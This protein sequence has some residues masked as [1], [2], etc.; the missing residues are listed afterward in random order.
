MERDQQGSRQ[1]ESYGLL[2]ILV[3]IR[4][5]DETVFHHIYVGVELSGIDHR[6]V[7]VKAHRHASGQKFVEYLVAH[8]V[9]GLEFQKLPQA[10]GRFVLFLHVSVYLSQK[11]NKKIGETGN[12]G[13]IILQGGGV[14]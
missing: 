7:G 5:A 14:A 6:A 3:H 4:A 9:F 11:I 8:D 2:Y 13:F 1:G 12:I 10:V